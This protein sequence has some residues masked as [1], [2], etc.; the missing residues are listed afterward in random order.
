MNMKENELMIDVELLNSAMQCWSDLTTFRRDRERCK[1]Y[2]YGDQWGDLM[3]TGDGELIREEEFIRRQGNLPLKNNL[4]HR[5]VRN[6]LGVF[7]NNWESP[8][9]EDAYLQQMPEGAIIQKLLDHN[10]EV[11][12]LEELYCRTMEEFLISGL[13]VHRKWFGS[14]GGRTD[15]W[16]DIVNP[17]NFFCDS[18]S[19]DFRGWDVSLVG[20][21]HD[22]EFSSLCAEFATSKEDVEMLE[23]IYG[24]SES[25]H[26]VRT[27]IRTGERSCRVIEVWRK[28]IREKYKCH[29]TITGRFYI[30]EKPVHREGVKC[31]WINEEGW[32]GYFLAPG[33]VVLRSGASPYNHGGHPFVFKAYPFIDGEI[34]SFVND[35]I[36]QQK[37]TNRLISM[38]DWTLRASAKGLLLFPEN[39]FPEGV[40]IN[41]VASEWGRFNG[42]IVYRPHA[43]MPMPQQVSS[44]TANT[45]ITD[46]LNIQMKLMEDISGVSGALQGRLDSSSMSGTLYN[47]QTQNSLIALTDLLRTFNGFISEATKMDVSNIRQY[48][49][50]ERIRKILG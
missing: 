42:V 8:K 23:R 12:Q 19:R 3:E 50:S 39:S 28:E 4:I 20:E 33:G 36:D 41:D 22:M 21:I 5:L 9:C 6:V 48:Y 38:Y 32:Y 30:S 29:D 1:R 25:P 47:Q 24:V 26:S 43:G 18:G 44:T 34:H 37:F 31:K 13:A 17:E 11:N 45:G 15:C 27:T 46:L 40:D 7:R 35:V 2:T 14:R 10:M 16:T 49:T